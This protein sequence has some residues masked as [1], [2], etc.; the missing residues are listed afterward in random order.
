MAMTPAD[1]RF[2]FHRALGL[3]HRGF[4]SLRTRGW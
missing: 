2:L 4:T 3:V 1:A